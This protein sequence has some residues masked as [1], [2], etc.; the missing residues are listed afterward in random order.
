M[1][2]RLKDMGMSASACVY[3]CVFEM[4]CGREGCLSVYDSVYDSVGQCVRVL[5][6]QSCLGL[7]PQCLFSLHNNQ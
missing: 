4:K 3:V 5:T 2:A 6:Q 7:F 1:Q